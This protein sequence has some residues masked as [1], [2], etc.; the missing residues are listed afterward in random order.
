MSPCTWVHGT[1]IKA[2]SM[3]AVASTRTLSCVHRVA[4][5]VQPQSCSYVRCIPMQADIVVWVSIDRARAEDIAAQVLNNSVA[6]RAAA[7]GMEKY[8][9]EETLMTSW[10]VPFRLTML[11]G[12]TGWSTE[13]ASLTVEERNAT[14]VTPNGTIYSRPARR[15][16]KYEVVYCRSS[17]VRFFAVMI[18]ILMWIMSLYL[19]VLAVDHV[20]FRPRTLEPD[21]VGFS[22]GMLFALPTL[23]MLLDAPLGA[24]I[25]MLG[26]TWCMLLVA[27]AVIIFFS[28][29]YT[30]HSHEGEVF[31]KVKS[32]QQVQVTS[33]SEESLAKV[34]EL[35]QGVDPSAAAAALR[36]R[37]TAVADVADVAGGGHVTHAVV[38]MSPDVDCVS[39]QPL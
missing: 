20:L 18:V 34:L 4:P 31:H 10:Q 30:D 27:L 11:P 26:F 28:G 37:K 3:L 6:Q 16:M 25:D 13:S 9:E 33:I 35:L 23:R 22:V 38:D 17:F 15:V 7:E 39:K 24:Y 12:V 2:F 32:A 1:A 8:S 19:L 36:R 29:A 21:T 5:V 14:Y